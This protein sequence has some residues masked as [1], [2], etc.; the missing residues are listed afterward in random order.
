MP[1]G[2]GSK[3]IDDI[4]EQAKEYAERYEA[5]DNEA[6]GPFVYMMDEFAREHGRMVQHLDAGSV[7]RLIPPRT[8]TPPGGW[9]TTP[10]SH[11]V[12]FYHP[13]HRP[14]SD[15]EHHKRV[16]AAAR[17]HAAQAARALAGGRN[18]R[19]RPAAA[20]AAARGHASRRA[21]SRRLR[22]AHQAA[23]RTAPGRRQHLQTGARSTPAIVTATS[24]ALA[25]RTAVDALPL[26]AGDRHRTCGG[27]ASRCRSVVG[28][29]PARL[30]RRGAGQGRTKRTRLVRWVPSRGTRSHSSSP[31]RRWV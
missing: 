13:G 24:A 15:T 28:D 7:L 6:R 16:P 18:R 17:P 2:S 4:M 26:H 3:S 19:L 22:G 10:P 21:R 23:G 12:Q 31:A 20:D 14:I 25:G 1:N 29:S 11:Q 8:S 5:L 27:I 30:P 9:G